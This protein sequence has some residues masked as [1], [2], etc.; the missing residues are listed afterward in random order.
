MNDNHTGPVPEDAPYFD[1]FLKLLPDEEQTDWQGMEYWTY[2]NDGE[3]ASPD[4]GEGPRYLGLHL[5]DW[6]ALADKSPRLIEICGMRDTVRRWRV[7]H[8]DFAL[9]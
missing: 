4:W 2:L 1:R 6:V 7:N 9:R 3:R 5:L 8:P